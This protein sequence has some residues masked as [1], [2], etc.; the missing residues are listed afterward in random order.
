MMGINKVLTFKLP[1]KALKT[2]ESFKCY[3]E[4]DVIKTCLML[5]EKIEE[6]EKPA[7]TGN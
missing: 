6:S 4:Y 1:V 2:A 5:R 7:V 3:S